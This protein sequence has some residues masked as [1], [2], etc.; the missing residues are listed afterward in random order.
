MLVLIAA[1]VDEPSESQLAAKMLS[2]P[3][4]VRYMPA[5]KACIK[6]GK[7]SH[8][9]CSYNQVNGNATCGNHGLLT[10]ILRDTWKWDGRFQNS[11]GAGR[12]DICYLSDHCL[13][14]IALTGRLRGE[15]L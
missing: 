14:T 9:M 12:T 15:R 3:L 1:V 6:D 8:V 10:T 5:F 7:S 2:R 4:L 13:T 11:L